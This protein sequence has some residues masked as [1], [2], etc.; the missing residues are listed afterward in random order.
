MT[1][2][3]AKRWLLVLAVWGLVFAS[4]SCS[5]SSSPPEIT[6]S[7]PPEVTTSQ[8]P[9][10]SGNQEI[11]IADI[12]ELS[13]NSMCTSSQIL[14]GDPDFYGPAS[15]LHCILDDSTGIVLRVYNE[16]SAVAEVVGNWDEVVSEENQIVYSDNWFAIGPEQALN[17]MFQKYEKNG[18][19]STIPET[20]ALSDSKADALL[21]SS[22]T[23]FTIQESIT[24]AA[25][26]ELQQYYENYPGMERT[27][28]YIVSEAQ[29]QGLDVPAEDSLETN[30]FLTRFD[31]E[32]KDFCSSASNK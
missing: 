11:T 26:E 9:E 31:T 16:Q 24:G 32:V 29:D 6:T 27:R 5:A 14:L 3:V 23:Y 10:L 1:V 20:I 7:Q 12:E 17:S 8:P 2:E 18:P 21:C 13:N 19:Q 28:D 15:G 25:R 30:V 22:V 4:T